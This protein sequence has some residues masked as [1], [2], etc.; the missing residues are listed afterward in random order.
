MCADCG[1]RFSL[2]WRLTVHLRVHSRE[3]PF[4]CSQC[5]RG[6]NN[7]K[8][9]RRH[10]ITHSS[11]KPFVCMHCSTH[12]RRKDNLER[13]IKN[14]H[15]DLANGK[16]KKELKLKEKTEEKAAN[17][18]GDIISDNVSCLAREPNTNSV[19]KSGSDYISTEPN[20][21]TDNI[22]IEAN[23]DTDYVSTEP[24]DGTDYIST[25]PTKESKSEPLKVI[26]GPP[27][28]ACK[29]KEFKDKFEIGRQV[30][31]IYEKILESN[32]DSRS[33]DEEDP[34]EKIIQELNKNSNNI[35][36]QHQLQ[37]LSI[38]SIHYETSFESGPHATIK[39]IK[40]KLPADYTSKI[41]KLQNNDQLIDN[42]K[43]YTELKSVFPIADAPIITDNQNCIRT[44]V[45][46]K[47]LNF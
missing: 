22:S 31:N 43:E 10:E 16:I 44:S 40:F 32:S 14:T 17:C 41:S 18:L 3:R 1:A 24:S 27:K 15:Y 6:F 20:E 25:E 42:V 38:P 13:H 7:L 36:K 21:C 11:E 5:Q 30:P 46:S 9:L 28:L 26:L 8:D 47:N 39:N 33:C 2:K 37:P 12:F 23:D 4:V 29:K 35:I 45:I 19:I 34:R